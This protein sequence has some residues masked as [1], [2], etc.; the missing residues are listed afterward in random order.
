MTFNVDDDVKECIGIYSIYNKVS[1]KFY[2]GQT[3]ESFR[4]R[5][6]RYVSSLKRNVCHN[7]HLQRSYNLYGDV[8]IFS[9]VCVCSD[10][11]ILD[12][13]EIKYI[14]EYREKYDCYN[15]LSGG[16]DLSNNNNPMFGKKLSEEH[17]NK[18]SKAH[19]G[20]RCGELNNFYGK[21]HSGE[22]NGFFGLSHSE[23]SKESIS[24][25]KAK[26][27]KDKCNPK[28][29]EYLTGKE[30][31]RK[32]KKVICLDT[33]KIYDSIDIAAKETNSH[34]SKISCVC[35]HKRKRT[36]GYSWMFLDEYEKQQAM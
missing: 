3:S 34:P 12:E 27:Y 14:A 33:L 6:N 21:D 19:K 17:K 29:K 26:L 8:F 1:N 30:N 35:S 25:T 9:V 18:L 11:K 7:E 16:H 36:N 22:N 24:L 4:K 32:R 31:P 15:I 20:K 23:D 2:I 10:A 28:Q 13:L 5:F